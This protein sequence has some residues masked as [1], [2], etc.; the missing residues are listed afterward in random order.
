MESAS[1]VV[2][3]ANAADIK[4]MLDFWKRRNSFCLRKTKSGYE[5]GK[6]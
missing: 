4:P 1:C 5:I 6:R 3:L 2:E